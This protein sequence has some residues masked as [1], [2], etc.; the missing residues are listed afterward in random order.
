[1]QKLLMLGECHDYPGYKLV[2]LSGFQ[3][4]VVKP[5]PK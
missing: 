1:M 3:L 4:S 2:V 5:K